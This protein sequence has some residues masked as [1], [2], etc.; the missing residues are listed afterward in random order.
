MAGAGVIARVR[1]VRG[2]TALVLGYGAFIVAEY[3]AWV[4]V[5]VYAY[6]RGGATEAG[7]IALAQLAPAALAAPV[8]ARWSERLRGAR[9]LQVGY[10]FL[11]LTLAGCGVGVLADLPALTYG[12]AVASALPMVV[13]RPAQIGVLTELVDDPLDLASGSVSLGWA[14][15]AGVV[16]AGLLAGVVLTGGGAGWLLLST[17]ALAVA[18]LVSTLPADA[19]TA[20]R[21]A[22]PDVSPGPTGPAPPPAAVPPPWRSV[23]P[24]VSLLT[25]GSVLV[26]ALDVL[27]VVLAVDVLRQGEGW[28]GYLQ[29]VFGLGAVLSAPITARLVGRRLAPAVVVAA[30]ATGAALAVTAPGPGL[31]VTVA[32]VMVV[33]GG[34][35]VLD[36]STRTLLLRVVPQQS[37]ART[38]GVVEGCTMGGLALGSLLVPVLVAAG[39]PSTALIGVACLLPLAVAATAGL[40]LRLDGEAPGHRDALAALR[41]SPLLHQ[42]PATALEA[43]AG[44]AE[45]CS[46]APG[47]AIMSEG[48]AGLDYH[49]ITGGQAEVTRA[50][51][52]LQHL[53]AGEGFGEIAL[54]RHSPRIA[55]VAALTPVTTLRLGGRAFLDAVTGHRA[56]LT[57]FTQHVDDRLSPTD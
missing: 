34:R 26:A 46:F 22:T 45:R 7:L 9:V 39:G 2:L 33:G 21:A 5:L 6:E 40:L 4:A 38:F 15:S 12:A 37:A 17:A 41:A 43:L 51:R 29:M 50:G 10:A 24:L 1:A 27:F 49:L 8:L 52:L 11:A 3:A 14:E 42:L 19:A 23:W 18:S 16:G 55:T 54:L 53:G 31:A 32:A 48:E 35:A 25:V 44:V 30:I 47:T 57:R 20:T 28:A 56:T 36:V 13:P